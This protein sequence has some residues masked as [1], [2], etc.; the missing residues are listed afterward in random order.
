LLPSVDHER[1]RAPL[2]RV[3][4]PQLVYPSGDPI[5]GPIEY[6]RELVVRGIRVLADGDRD[7]TLGVAELLLHLFPSL[8]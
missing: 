2:L 7:L 6:P 3:S 5:D 8:K 1:L 4:F